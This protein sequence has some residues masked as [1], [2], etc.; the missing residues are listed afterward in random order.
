MPSC[1]APP[2]ARSAA[3]ALPCWILDTS[4]LLPVVAFG[5]RHT[6]ASNLSMQPAPDT[7]ASGVQRLSGSLGGPA[8]PAALASSTSAAASVFPFMMGLMA[9]SFRRRT[10]GTP[11]DD[12]PV[13]RADCIAARRSAIDCG[14][15]SNETRQDA[16][17]GRPLPEG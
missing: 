13:A 9:L 3:V 8:A 1:V 7:T 4:A 15:P 14:H 5:T 16:A 6:L 11:R 17:L 2:A 10:R 12:V